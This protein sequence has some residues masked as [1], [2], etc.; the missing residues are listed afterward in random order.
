MNKNTSAI[1][2]GIALLATG[3]SAEAVTVNNESKGAVIGAVLGALIGGPPGLI[4]GAGGGALIGHTSD[5][6]HA[7][8]G[9]GQEL[10]AHMPTEP[11]RSA[12]MLAS[13]ESVAS[14]ETTEQLSEQHRTYLE[15]LSQGLALTI[16]FR[17]GSDTL[18]PH[19]QRQ[20]VAL[21]QLLEVFPEL[22]VHLEGHADP[23]GS[24]D[25]NQALS[26]KRVESIARVLASGG[27][28]AG[29]LQTTALGE[30]QPVSKTADADAYAFDR[31]VVIRLMPEQTGSLG[32]LE[33]AVVHAESPET[34]P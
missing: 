27:L 33:D 8:E 26:A 31:R 21:T 25:Y 3:V 4:V 17:T 29:R 24:E 14:D 15:P 20:L 16:H 5:L 9:Q 18:E 11:D 28:A 2:L 34:R 19:L 7:V 6:Q 30:T 13:L 10:A 23:R 22:Q 32:A 1:L 12:T